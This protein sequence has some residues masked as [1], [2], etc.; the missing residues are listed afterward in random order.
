MDE[1]LLAC[2]TALQSQP[3]PGQPSATQT[4]TLEQAKEFKPSF[5]VLDALSATGLRALRYAQELPFITSITANDLSP[6]AVEMIALNIKHNKL[7][8]KI[9]TST[10]NANAHMYSLVGQEG[11]GG[12]GS[13]YEVIDID[14]YGTAVPFLDAAIQALSN[15]GLLC[16]TCTDSGVFNSIGYSEKT[17]SL[18][19]GLPV[20][21]EHCH[22]AGL[23]LILHAIATSAAKYGISVEPLLSLSIDYYARVFVRVRKSPAEVKFHSSK[24]MI[25]Y[26][27]DHGCGAWQTQ[28]LARALPQTA[29]NGQVSYKHGA[30]QGPSTKPLCEHCGSKMHVS[31]PQARLCVGKTVK[32]W[33]DTQRIRSRNQVVNLDRVL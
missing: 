29:K 7:E 26:S 9:V 21:G 31:L 14:P 20:K 16:V 23:R 33:W 24:T 12:P 10:G 25:V 32:T 15:G 27:C 17:F 11:R 8:D 28:F 19:G 1:D 22:E 13:K 30:A 4:E 18:Y 6:K 5:R 2:E 3:T